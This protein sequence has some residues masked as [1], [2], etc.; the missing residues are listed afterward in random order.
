[1]RSTLHGPEAF[2]LK[3][4]KPQIQLLISKVDSMTEDQIR[5]LDQ[6]PDVIK[7]LLNIKR[8]KEQ[9]AAAAR[10]ELLADLMI[11]KYNKNLL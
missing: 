2:L 8:R 3:S 10:A 5:N 7:A 6:K 11:Q 9:E 1:M 4:K